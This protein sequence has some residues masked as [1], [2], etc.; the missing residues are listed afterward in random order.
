MAPRNPH[1]NTSGL[2]R[3]AGP[4]RPKGSKGL[5]A[6]LRQ[7]YGH[8]ARR[9]LAEIE[10]IARDGKAPAKVRLS[11]WQYIV[12]RM[13]GRPTQSVDHSGLPSVPLFA[14]P[15]GMMPKVSS[16]E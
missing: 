10:E 13:E 6:Y 8:D 16:K 2:K 5:K 15:D 7:K 11:A 14:L 1:P 4:G 12:D 9:A 3:T